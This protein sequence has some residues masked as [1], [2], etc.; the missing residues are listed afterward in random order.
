M[1][2][3][4]TR[5]SNRPTDLCP[6]LCDVDLYFCLLCDVDLY[7]CLRKLHYNVTYASVSSTPFFAKT[8]L[9]FG[10]WHAYK[11]CV[12]ECYCRFLPLWAALE[13]KQILTDPTKVEILT[14]FNLSMMESML[15][16]VFLCTHR[17]VPLIRS[18]IAQLRRLRDVY[19]TGAVKLQQLHGMLALLRDYA[20][21]LWYLGY[22]V[23]TLVQL[24][25]RS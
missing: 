25:V 18:A 10:V 16:S 4:R 9:L 14:D 5:T 17:V 13:Y 1:E 6:L 20:P 24:S 21:P 22:R 8:P 15:L 3:W 23:P 11:Y 12:T 7:F 2:E 19:G